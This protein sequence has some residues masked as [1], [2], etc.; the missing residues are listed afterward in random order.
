[1]GPRIRAYSEPP[2]PSRGREDLRG[3][4]SRGSRER[5]TRLYE[6]HGRTTYWPGQE[7]LAANRAIYC[8]CAA[9]M[10]MYSVPARSSRPT[11]PAT[12]EKYRIG[13]RLRLINALIRSPTLLELRLAESKEDYSLL[14]ADSGQGNDDDG[15]RDQPG[16]P[17][18]GPVPTSASSSSTCARLGLMASMWQLSRSRAHL[19]RASAARSWPGAGSLPPGPMGGLVPFDPAGT[20]AHDRPGCRTCTLRWAAGPARRLATCC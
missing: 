15:D 3:P 7:A 13:A 16:L 12:R 18:R 11:V 10:Y 14:I 4:D 6:C 5:S 19:A 9:S 2:R 20:R 8:R 17:D 1:M